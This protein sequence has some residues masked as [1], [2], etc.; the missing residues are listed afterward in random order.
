MSSDGIDVDFDSA[1]GGTASALEK[2]LKHHVAVGA[3]VIPQHFVELA[4]GSERGVGSRSLRNHQ[5][6][7]DGRFRLTQGRLEQLSKPSYCGSDADVRQGSPRGPPPRGD[8]V[9]FRDIR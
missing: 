5:T 2:G 8:V 9:Q 6:Q 3:L 7:L 1:I 4:N